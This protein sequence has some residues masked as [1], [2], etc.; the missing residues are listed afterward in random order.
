MGLLDD[1]KLDP[2]AAGLQHVDTH[3]MREGAVGHMFQAHSAP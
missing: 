2:I 3:A 1:S